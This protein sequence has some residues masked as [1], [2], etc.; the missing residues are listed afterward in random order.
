VTTRLSVVLP[1]Y[2]EAATVAAIIEKVMALQLPDV[3]IEVIVVESNSTDGSRQIVQRYADH[4]RVKLIL[5]DRPS[6]KGN[7]VRDGFRHATGDIVLIQDGD[8]EYRVEDYPIVLAPLISG[9]TNFVLGCRHAPGKPIRHL[10]GARHTS[11]VMNGAHWA[12]TTMFNVVY[13]TK[14]RDPFTMYKVFRTSCIV[15]VP[16]TSNRFD[17]DW[18]LV[19]KLVRLGNIPVEVPITY[20]SRNFDSGKKVRFFRDPL[21]WMV[22]LAKF[23]FT[24]LTAADDDPRVALSRLPVA[25]D[26]LPTPPVKLEPLRDGSTNGAP[27]TETVE[28]RRAPDDPSDPEDLSASVTS[29]GHH[30]PDGD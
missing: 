25:V 20:A 17:F 18:E 28:A 11:L 21:T 14:L 27:R 26:P 9:E 29:L 23:R 19:A 2:N 30:G 8:L 10:E 1:V 6:G 3:E 24:K 13:R 16:F 4:P 7:A 5:Q 12:F 15:G 22:A